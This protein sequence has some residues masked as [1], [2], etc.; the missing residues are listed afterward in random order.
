MCFVMNKND[1]NISSLLIFREAFNTASGC[2][3]LCE[4]NKRF[5]KKGKKL[6]CRTRQLQLPRD[7]DP[8]K[9]L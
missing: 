4:R 3:N 5:S 7:R 8:M 6:V 9:C 1:C 2:N